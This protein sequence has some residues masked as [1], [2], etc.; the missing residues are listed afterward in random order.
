LQSLFAMPE[1]A[2]RYYRPDEMIPPIAKP[3]EDLEVQLRKV[4]DG[5]L[6]GRY[7][8]PG[9]D[10]QA[11]EEVPE[12]P[13]QSGLAPAMLKHLI[14]RGHSEFSTMRQQDGF[15]LLLHLLKLVTRSQA[16]AQGQYKDVSDPVEAFRFCMEQKLKCL[17]CGKVKLRTDEMENLS[18]AVPIKRLPQDASAKSAGDNDEKPREEFEPV[19]LRQCIDEFTAAE[20]VELN[21]AG[22]G[23]KGFTK[24][25]LFK[26]FP[27]IFAVNARRFE[28]VNWVPTKQDVPVI[29]DEEDFDLEAY[30]S[31]GKL[32]DEEELPEDQD[33][34]SGAS[35]A[36]VPNEMAL[37]MLMSMGFPKVRCERA[38]HATGNQDPEAATQWLFEHMEDRDIDTPLSA[39]GGGGAG[40]VSA[41]P[42][43]VENLGMMGFAAPVARCLPTLFQW[44]M[45]WR[46]NPWPF[47]RPG[48]R[49]SPRGQHQ[50]NTQAK[51]ESRGR[52]TRENLKVSN[53]GRAG[54]REVRHPVRRTL[55]RVRRTALGK[56]RSTTNPLTTR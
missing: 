52:T 10:V 24:Q 19:T 45:L 26:T 41:D 54:R 13:W 25:Q 29:V 36:F 44:R 11:S 38:L 49:T 15:E 53:Q 48:G 50:T 2:H 40:N 18:V 5:L 35:N 31:P 23:N 34:G 8:Q 33:A 51:A 21:C 55:L 14:G 16:A 4:A 47:A 17:G 37:E 7:G 43:K 46:E 56:W 12:Q 9:S 22:C 42:E 6:S 1:F 28:I 20:H 30:R 3:A 32:P 39:S 27:T